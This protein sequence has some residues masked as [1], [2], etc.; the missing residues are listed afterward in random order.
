VLDIQSLPRIDKLLGKGSNEFGRRNAFFSR[1]LLH[2]L[3][4]LI[5]AG[6][7]KHLLAFEPMI[8]RDDIGE[9]L[10]V[11]MAYV[12]RR[13]GVI[14]RGCNEEDVGHG[15]ITWRTCDSRATSCRCRT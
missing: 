4:M 7:E 15:A 5:D 2:L 3:A 11:S 6:Q 1:R 12:R 14:D 13:V 9:H 8:T 10:F